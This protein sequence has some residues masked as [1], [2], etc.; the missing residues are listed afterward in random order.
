V[1]A[2]LL[3]RIYILVLFGSSMAYYN[4]YFWTWIFLGIMNNTRVS[5]FGIFLC[6]WYLS[7][8]INTTSNLVLSNLC[9]TEEYTCTPLLPQYIAIIITNISTNYIHSVV[10]QD[11]VSGRAFCVNRITMSRDA[12]S[13]RNR[14]DLIWSLAPT[15]YVCNKFI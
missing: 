3:C 10:V 9:Y 13:S 2:C 11:F 6:N 7:T 14:Q 5:Y 1:V 12:V 15:H 4:C 8:T